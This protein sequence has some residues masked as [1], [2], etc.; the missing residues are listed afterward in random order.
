[1]THTMLKGSNVP[2]EAPAVRA[3]LHW[4]TVGDGGPDVDASALVVGESGRVRA[5][6]DFV[7]YNQPRHPSGRVRHLGKGR[8][9]DGATDS[10][11]ADL[12]AL[13]GSVHRVLL[14]ASA[15]GGTFAQ[16]PGLRLS[17][18]DASGDEL[19]TFDIVPETGS[20]TAMIC[21]ELYRRG[22][23]WK[24]RALGQGYDTG[25]VALASEYGISVAD[26]AS[27]EPEGTVPDPPGEPDFPDPAPVP[28]PHPEPEPGPQPPL[29]E[30][31]GPG[32]VPEPPGPEPQPQPA[33]VGAFAVSDEQATAPYGYPQPG[34]GQ[35]GYPMPPQHPPRT[36]PAYGYPQ[37]AYGYPQQPDPAFVLPPQGPQ[38]LRR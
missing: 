29:P 24:F 17:V 22:A 19:V 34:S 12:D 27:A 25:L 23:G 2:L 31:P 38:F 35:G 11:E 8:D 28:V 5:D 32:P 14:V 26:D 20:E 7:F 10:V 6:E 4:S 30:P 33:G 16:V 13:E 15:D 37:P 9:D 1:M 3:V 18:R 36:Q 21:G